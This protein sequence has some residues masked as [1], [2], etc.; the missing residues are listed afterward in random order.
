MTHRPDCPLCAGDGGTLI[1][2]GEGFRVIR[3]DEPD[4]PAFYRLIWA[5]HVAEFSDL[6]A[7]QRAACMDAVVLMEQA[8]RVHLQPDKVNLAT[9]GN[10][11]PHLHWHVIARWQWDA[12]WPQPVW[13]QQRRDQNVPCLQ[14]VRAQLPGVDAALRRDLTLRFAAV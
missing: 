5:D 3:A 6:P 14:W 11:V 10:V 12:H 1:W 13:S 2:R 8:L 7:L 9:L 4:H